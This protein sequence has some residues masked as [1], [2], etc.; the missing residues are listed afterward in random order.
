MKVTAVFFTFLVGIAAVLLLQHIWTSDVG[1]L[2]L[3]Y[4]Q[5]T[6][7]TISNGR[8]FKLTSP[9]RL[10][11]PQGEL[12]NT[13]IA[14]NLSSNHV[15][16][17]VD[18][19]LFGLNTTVTKA[20]STNTNHKNVSLSDLVVTETGLLPT[21]NVV[22]ESGV[23]L[24]DA[25]GRKEDSSHSTTQVTQKDTQT[26]QSNTLLTS[27]RSS[28][29]KCKYDFK[30]YVYEVPWSIPSVR[31]AAEARVNRTLHVCKKCLM[32]QFALE[33]I[34]SDFFLQF[35]GRTFDPTEADFFYLPLIRDA[36]YRDVLL[37]KSNAKR[38]PSYTEEA[39]LNIIE[40]G[41]SAK[42]KDYFNITDKFW[43]ARGGSDHIIVMP[44]PVTNLRHES[45][46]RGFFHYMFHLH[47][48]IF[49]CLEYSLSFVKEYPV[50]S[51]QKNV[52]VP[53]PT[54]DP[55][56][57]N[58]KL[59]DR[60]IKRSAL[61]YYAG[62]IHGD[63]IV[64]RKAMKILVMESA[65]LPGVLPHVKSIQA[66]REHGF[67]AATFCPVPVGD[68]PSSKRMYDVMNFGCI[69]V[70]LSDDLLWAFSQQS[71]GP[72]DHTSFSIQMPQAVVQFSAGKLLMKYNTTKSLLG[73]LPDGEHIYD[74]LEASHMAGGSLQGAVRVNALVQILQKVSSKNIEILRT[75]VEAA[76]PHYRYYLMNS[77]MKTIPTAEHRF[78]TGGAIDMLALQLSQIKAIGTDNIRTQCIKERGQKHKYLDHYPCDE[79]LRR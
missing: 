19:G 59:H 35:C 13:E 31:L 36:E 45:G 26:N 7:S 18:S 62:G 12:D 44:A 47:T 76:A 54:T 69:P 78:P 79:S 16:A 75:G 77:S 46:K 55:D 72:L 29:Q 24:K 21:K 14:T 68:S 57:Y 11:S 74:L 39:L 48:P 37:G 41:N 50:C 65:T 70:V 61:M 15:F 22:E 20:T 56:L 73:M 30:V 6:A 33:Y 52:I 8:Y 10:N 4:A 60:D 5:S 71:G 58:G 64:V 38:K 9:S 49:L 23:A 51:T 66:E 28:S 67:R 2:F 43:R 42:W 53:Y 34:V 63:C 25:N 27:E 32:E 17:V 40:K 3:S 1:K